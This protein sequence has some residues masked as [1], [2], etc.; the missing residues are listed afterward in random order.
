MEIFKVHFLIYRNI[1]EPRTLS[2]KKNGGK[3]DNLLKNIFSNYKDDLG[4][5][6]NDDYVGNDDNENS[7][8]ILSVFY[9][10]ILYV[11]Y[12]ILIKKR[13]LY[14]SQPCYSHLTRLQQA[15]QGPVRSSDMAH[16]KFLSLIM[17]PFYI[18]KGIQTSTNILSGISVT[19]FYFRSFQNSW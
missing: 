19:Y 6:M 14:G 10:L 17:L 18:I 3:N 16:T 13:K 2:E 15:C 7:F 11:H 9:T 8:Y 12:L 4:D 1:K 5:N